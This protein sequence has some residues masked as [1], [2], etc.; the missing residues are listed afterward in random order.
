[1][2]INLQKNDLLERLRL[3]DKTD[4][5]INSFVHLWVE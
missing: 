2:A 5:L 1:M 4:C 3:T